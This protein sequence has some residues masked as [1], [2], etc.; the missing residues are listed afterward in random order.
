MKFF[1]WANDHSPGKHLP[2]IHSLDIL[3]LIQLPN[4][5]YLVPLERMLSI[6]VSLARLVGLAECIQGSC[7]LG[8]RVLEARWDVLEHLR[9]IRCLSL[10]K[11]II[12]LDYNVGF[13]PFKKIKSHHRYVYK[14]N[15]AYIFNGKNNFFLKK[16]ALRI[17]DI[18]KHR[19]PLSQTNTYYI[20]K[21]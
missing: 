11:L 3:G 12:L 6:R 17:P 5:W 2:L 21:Y 18:E 16:E 10:G 19:I 4:H 14:K 8:N 1:A 9:N 20:H 13:F 15:I 7:A